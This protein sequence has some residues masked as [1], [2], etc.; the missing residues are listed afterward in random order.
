MFVLN[1][2]NGQNLGTRGTIAQDKLGGTL[3]E[4]AARLPAQIKENERIASAALGR[5]AEPWEGYLVHQQGEG[6]GAALLK[7]A[8]SE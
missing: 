6:G 3:D 7:A 4:Q 1:L 8:Y 5:T 2:H